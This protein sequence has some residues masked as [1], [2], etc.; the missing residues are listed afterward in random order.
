MYAVRLFVF[1]GLVV[2]SL[3][4]HAQAFQASPSEKQAVLIYEEDGITTVD[5]LA[6]AADGWPEIV[7]RN[8]FHE[9]TQLKNFLRKNFPKRIPGAFAAG[10]ALKSAGTP[11]WKVTNQWN[12]AFEVE[13]A[14]WIRTDVDKDFFVR[15]G[16][17]TDCADVAYALRWIFAR[18]HGLPMTSRLASGDWMNQDSMRPAWLKLPTANEWYDDKRFL[19]ALDYLLDFTFTHTLLADSYP[20]AVNLN[21]VMEG[22]Y[23]LVTHDNTGHTRPFTK[24]LRPG[25]TGIPIYILQSTTPRS[26][27]ELFGDG[28]WVQDVPVKGQSGLLRFR[29][30]DGT[31]KGL[32]AADHMPN[33][34]EEQYDP[35]FTESGE[36]FYVAVFRHLDPSF[37]MDKLAT[38]FLKST[39]NSVLFRKQ[40]VED[41]FAFCSVNDC[42]EGSPGYEAWSTP[43]RDLRLKQM[44]AQLNQLMNMVPSDIRTML[45]NAMLD[46]LL[47]LDNVDYNLRAILWSWANNT[48]SV[49]PR[50]SKSARW[51]LSGESVD[52]FL[53]QKSTELWQTRE[54]FIATTSSCPANIC[55][56]HSAAWNDR[57]TRELDNK[58]AKLLSL[59]TD[60]CAD[61]PATEC[62]EFKRRLNLPFAL[63]LGGMSLQQTLESFL[64]INNDPRHTVQVRREGLGPAPFYVGQGASLRST[65]NFLAARDDGSSGVRIW[66][67]RKTRTEIPPPAGMQ[68]LMPALVSNRAWFESNQG[69]GVRDLIKGTENRVSLS[70]EPDAAATSNQGS[71]FFGILRASLL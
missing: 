18:A 24:V 38:E 25:E 55:I 43:S 53:R 45:E 68:W 69:V 12:W 44:L 46:P 23:H 71:A 54:A 36:L 7:Q 17:A 32:I 65:A 59:S 4:L 14:N 48:Y 51:G 37:T 19:A 64:G 3:S 42:S 8:R 6:R 21:S 39:Q 40:I 27:Q 41:G 22:G 67:I 63:R 35:A 56:P 16:I 9:P 13:L 20:T 2:S 49:D 28:Y 1:L 52:A 29:W 58:L 61:A 60:Y 26:V 57:S 11:L 31:G 5:Q 30:P 34:S 10:E 47:K 70:F 62:A 15:H 33:Y 66:D 50:V